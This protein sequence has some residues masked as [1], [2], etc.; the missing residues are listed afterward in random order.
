MTSRVWNPG[1]PS[2]SPPAKLDVEPSHA[3]QSAY[4]THGNRQ[5]RAWERLEQG[6]ER[7]IVVIRINRAFHSL[8]RPR[9]SLP[10]VDRNLTGLGSWV[11]PL[12]ERINIGGPCSMTPFSK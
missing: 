2:K 6:S 10:E 3:D 7:R 11:R 9:I 8:D 12:P 4:D 5:S 1:P